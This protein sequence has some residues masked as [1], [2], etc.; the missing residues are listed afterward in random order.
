LAPG[1]RPAPVRAGPLAQVLAPVRL[2]LRMRVKVPEPV[3]ER[4]RAME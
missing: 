1:E 2:W 3:R 4:V